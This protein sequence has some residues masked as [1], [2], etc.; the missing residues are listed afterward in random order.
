MST[1]EKAIDKLRSG[2]AP[3]QRHEGRPDADR[4]DKAALSQEKRDAGDKAG[5]APRE[6]KWDF[7]QLDAAGMIIKED[8]KNL[9][10]EEYRQIKRPLL[11]NAFATGAAAIERGNVI[12][13][14]SALPG[15]GKTF[16]TMNLAMSIALERD[17]TVLLVDADVARPAVSHYLNERPSIGLIDY[18]VNDKIG[19]AD[20]LLHTDVPNLRVLPAGRQHPH[21]TELLASR[22]M[23]QLTL[24]LSSRY[25][26][27]V[28]LFDSPPLLATTEAAV[29]AGLMGQIVVVVEA[30]RT[31]KEAVQEALSLLDRNAIISLILNKSR[32]SSGKAYYSYYHYHAEST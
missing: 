18:L 11:I 23:Q 7:S 30:E 8:S 22:R 13:I 15:E 9:I 27:R 31:Q 14:T 2:Q 3:E 25:P 16:S 21:S 5:T 4:L 24:E 6:I 32:Q 19:V 28:I 29:L 12:M 17:K 20:V 10:A 1:I 26:D